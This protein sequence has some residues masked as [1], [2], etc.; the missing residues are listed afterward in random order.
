[1]KF[2]SL[3]SAIRVSLLFGGTFLYAHCT[4]LDYLGVR[5]GIE[6]EYVLVSGVKCGSGAYCR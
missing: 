5:N 1:M 3:L 6:I 2:L 4:V